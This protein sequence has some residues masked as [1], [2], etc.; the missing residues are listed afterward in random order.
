[1]KHPILWYIARH[2]DAAPGCADEAIDRLDTAMRLA[3]SA[4]AATAMDLAAEALLD[5]LRNRNDYG[6]T[7]LAEY[8]EAFRTEVE[9]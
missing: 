1:M 4:T 7:S 6:A 8:M 5:E 3:P 9:K 2:V